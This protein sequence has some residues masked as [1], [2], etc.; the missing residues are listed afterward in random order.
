[1]IVDANSAFDRKDFRTAEPLYQRAATDAALIDERPSGGNPGPGLRAFA[2]FRLLL[3][4]A[5][6]GKDDEAQ[7]ILQQMQALDAAT[8]Y[9]AAAQVFWHAYGQTGSVDAGCSQFTESARRQ[10]ALL[11]PL[12]GWGYASAELTAEKLCEVP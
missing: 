10:P 8:P 1:M 5:I 4:N 3:R 2:R 12:T 11:E 7:V 9:P 6:A